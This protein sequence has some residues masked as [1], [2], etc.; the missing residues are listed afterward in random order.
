MKS[1]MLSA[2]GSSPTPEAKCDSWA[3]AKSLLDMVNVFR[4]AIQEIDGY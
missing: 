1:T 3:V 2:E 4:T